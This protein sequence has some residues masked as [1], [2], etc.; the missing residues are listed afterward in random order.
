MTAEMKVSLVFGK[1]LLVMKRMEHCLK[2]RLTHTGELRLT[3]ML[4]WCVGV[5]DRV[6]FI[7]R[8]GRRLIA[9][10]AELET[11]GDKC[12]VSHVS[13]TVKLTTE[14]I[15]KGCDRDTY[16]LESQRRLC[17]A[18]ML[19]GSITDVHRYVLGTV[20]AHSR[21]SKSCCH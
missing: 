13:V 3:G 15:G 8:D 10:S 20:N 12:N 14:H 4:M 1:T 7:P 19:L 9:A 5:S 21:N 11:C 2:V 17:G 18:F 6:E 16:S